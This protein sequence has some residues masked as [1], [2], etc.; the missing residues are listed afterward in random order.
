[1]NLSVLNLLP[2]I[3]WV[4]GSALSKAISSRR[5]RSP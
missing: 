1:M 3:E 5:G 4:A 2:F